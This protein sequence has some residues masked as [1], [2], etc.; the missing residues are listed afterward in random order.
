MLLSLSLSQQR[1]LLHLFEHKQDNLQ[2][3]NTENTIS[4]NT[5]SED[6]QLPVDNLLLQNINTF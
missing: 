4:N 2:Y 5:L 1:T 3:I 6:D